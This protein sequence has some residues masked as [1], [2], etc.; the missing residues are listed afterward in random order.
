M[1]LTP[2]QPWLTLRRTTGHG[3]TKPLRCCWNHCGSGPMVCRDD[4]CARLEVQ[5][6]T[7]CRHPQPWP[8]GSPAW[9]QLKALSKWLKPIEMALTQGLTHFDSP[10]LWL[11]ILEP[12]ESTI[13]FSV[14]GPYNKNDHMGSSARDFIHMHVLSPSDHIFE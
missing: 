8:S 7:R 2:G 10:S 14:Y 6:G 9:T 1:I 5:P 3:C 11:R 13:N 4:G 12:I